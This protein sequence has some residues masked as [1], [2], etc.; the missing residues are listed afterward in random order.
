MVCFS[1]RKMDFDPGGCDSSKADQANGIERTFNSGT[2]R[3]LFALVIRQHTVV[4]ARVTKRDLK[5]GDALPVLCVPEI[6][7][8]ADM[9]ALAREQTVLTQ[10]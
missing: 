2:V 7:R 5:I 4:S 8:L 9:A 1:V 10:R 6:Q 3:K